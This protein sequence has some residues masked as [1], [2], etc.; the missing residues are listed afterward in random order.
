MPAETGYNKWN[1]DLPKNTFCFKKLQTRRTSYISHQA[2]GHF[3]SRAKGQLVGGWA[4]GVP[5][6]SGAWCPKLGCEKE[7]CIASQKTKPILQIGGSCRCH[8]PSLHICHSTMLIWGLCQGICLPDGGYGCGCVMFCVT[9]REYA[10]VIGR[11]FG[12][13]DE[14]P[15][16][17]SL[18]SCIQ[19]G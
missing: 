8:G 9:A 13:A 4:F 11:A 12:S 14:P 18:P 2:G 1:S 10:M 6:R 15:L 19:V 5:W 7:L 17:R 3:K 16:R